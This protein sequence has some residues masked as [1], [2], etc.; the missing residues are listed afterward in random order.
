MKP[1]RVVAYDGRWPEMFARER[2]RLAG[3]LGPAAA[4]IHHV[5]STS[6]PGMCAKPVLDVLVETPV[7]A[8]MDEATPG[9]EAA[10]YAARGEHGIPGRRYFSR[11]PGDRP[12]I[13]LHAYAVGD[14]RVARHLRFRDYLRAHP[15]AAERY[16]VLKRALARA[17]RDDAGAYQ[18]GKAEL[19]AEIDA[20]AAALAEG[21]EGGG[22]PPSAG[23]GEA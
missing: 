12:E 21:A 23:L 2:D 15:D 20:R 8:L 3:V 17:H 22:G 14:F 18:D 13:H 5:G 19:I 6:I 10:G 7:L 4:A 9:L 11:P 16:A 1:V